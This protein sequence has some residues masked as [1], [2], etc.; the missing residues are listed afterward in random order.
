MKLSMYPPNHLLSLIEILDMQTEKYDIYLNTKIS[1]KV[2][3]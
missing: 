2:P 3:R 1:L